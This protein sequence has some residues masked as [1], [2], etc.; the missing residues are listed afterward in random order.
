MKIF[1]ISLLFLF[2]AA[3]LTS[4]GSHEVAQD[5]KEDSVAISDSLVK[6]AKTAM[7]EAGDISDVIKLNGK[8]Q[9]NESKQAKVYALVSGKIKSVHVELGDYVRKGQTLAVIQSTEVA[10]VSSNLSLAESDVAMAKKSLE[11]TKDLYEGKLATEQE[12]I[13]AKMTYNKALAEL[14][15]SKQVSAISG[16]RNSSYVLTA[17]ITG[18]II[19]K[20][21]TNNSEVRSDNNTNLFAIADLSNVWV[22]ANVYEA[23]MNNIHLGD[24]VKVN[25]LADPNKDYVGKID[26]IYNVLDPATRTMK[27]RISMNNQNG[28]LKPEMFATVKVSGRP[29]S[30]EVVSIPSQSIV[31]NNSKNFVVVKKGNKLEIR[32]ISII[33]RVDPTAFVSGVS[34]GE[35]VVTENQVFFFQALNTK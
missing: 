18:F 30:N 25:T 1:K 26:K 34:V 23:D 3:M 4:C 20:N 9:P 28:E 24:E 15:R 5:P 7:A 19:E 14:N 6:T 2:I 10:G 17:P 31:L 13:S 32:E 29:S 16:G 22:I 27:V 21:I 11:T 35:E 12:F 8:I 33:K